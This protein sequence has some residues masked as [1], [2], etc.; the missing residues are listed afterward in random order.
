MQQKKEAEQGYSSGVVRGEPH[1]AGVVNYHSDV[2][3][4]NVKWNVVPPR[5]AQNF[6]HPL[7]FTLH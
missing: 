3:N 2:L 1:K 6:N 7:D 4:W 5:L